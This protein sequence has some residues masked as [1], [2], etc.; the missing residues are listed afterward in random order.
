M[1]LLKLVTALLGLSREEE[2]LIKLSGSDWSDS[3]LQK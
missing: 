1:M 3:T 2:M